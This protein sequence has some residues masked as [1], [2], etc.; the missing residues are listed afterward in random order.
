MS[1]SLFNSGPLISKSLK[2]LIIKWGRFPL[3]IWMILDTFRDPKRIVKAAAVFLFSAVLVV[4]S[5]LLQKFVHW[6]V[7]P[8]RMPRDPLLPVSGPFRNQNALAAYLAC[9]I[10]VALSFSLWK[11]DRVA[12]RVSLSLMTI[13]LITC[14]IWT[15]SRGGLIGLIV[16]LILVILLTN[17]HRMEE[18]VFWRLFLVTY[19][20]IMPL[21]TLV[22]FF[23]NRGSD[24]ERIIL[25]RGAWHMIKEHPFLG[26]GLGTFMDHCAQYTNNFA[27]SYAHNCYVQ[28]WAESGIFSLLSFLLFAGYV[29]YR[30]IKV[31]LRIPPSLNSFLLI[32]LSAGLLGFLAH[33]FFEVHLYSFQLS[34]LFWAVLGLAVAMTSCL[35]QGK[36]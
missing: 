24:N 10:P 26:L 19:I 20:F 22:L 33:S 11:W 13:M 29:F 35:E 8:G 17:Y 21:I 25:L 28:I 31:S 9:V 3:L 14:S 2:A 16:G 27:V 4:V 34:F 7:I 23:T 36:R 1:L 32:G 5:V 18:K 12:A 6:E 30:S 15:F